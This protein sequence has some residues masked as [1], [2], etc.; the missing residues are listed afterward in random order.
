M[1]EATLF[2]SREERKKRS[3]MRKSGATQV[4]VNSRHKNSQK[5]IKVS[6][7]FFAEWK[8]V[9]LLEAGYPFDY[10]PNDLLIVRITLAGIAYRFTILLERGRDC[11]ETVK[12][13]SIMNSGLRDKMITRRIPRRTRI[14]S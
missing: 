14:G 6:C 13:S 4:F 2:L 8:V 9:R 11:R 12:T 7:G 3:F 5:S 1:R 10:S